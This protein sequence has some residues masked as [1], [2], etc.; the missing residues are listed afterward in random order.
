MSPAITISRGHQ[1]R[2]NCLNEK[3]TMSRE[4]IK[5]TTP[6]TIKATAGTRYRI[7]IT[8]LKCQPDGIRARPAKIETEGHHFSK[9]RGMILSEERKR[10][11]PTRMKKVAKNRYRD[12]LFNLTAKKAQ[13]DPIIIKKKAVNTEIPEIPAMVP[14]R[15][16]QPNS[17]S[18]RP[19]KKMKRAA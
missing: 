18:R 15:N 19:P 8:P 11:K 9:A 10:K 16:A 5:S 1:L 4:K 3:L 7:L 2:M 14:N 17:M 13:A 6:R 12:R